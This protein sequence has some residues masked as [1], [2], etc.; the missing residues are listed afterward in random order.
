MRITI[1]LQ[2]SS[3][4]V[5]HL[6]SQ[7]PA[8][9]RTAVNKRKSITE[10]QLRSPPRALF[11]AKLEEGKI[12]A[13]RNDLMMHRST[14]QPF[15]FPDDGPYS[16]SQRDNCVGRSEYAPLSRLRDAIRNAAF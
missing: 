2:D 8:V 10:A 5:D 1:V 4:K 16:F 15:P 7:I 14:A 9:E 11:F 3:E 13:T 6:L 12:H